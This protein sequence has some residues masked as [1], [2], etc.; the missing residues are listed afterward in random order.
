MGLVSMG[1]QNLHSLYRL[2][3]RTEAE[4]LIVDKIKSI[5]EKAVEERQTASLMLSG[6]ST[7]KNV[8]SALSDQNLPWENVTIGL[9]DD[10]WVDADKPGSNERMLNETLMQNYA[11]KA[12]LIGMKT[13]HA[14][15]NQGA[16]VVSEKYKKIQQ[17]FDLCLMG[18]GTDGHT[19][20]WFPGSSG[21]EQALNIDNSELACAIDASNSP[22]AGK[23]PHRMTLSLPAVMNSRQI[24]LFITGEEKLSVLQASFESSVDM[25]PVKA[26]LAAGARLSVFWAP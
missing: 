2:D 23:F 15:V 4:A 12:R 10:R 17:P 6:G 5:V 20:S 7:P 25:M 19:A 8:Y 3:N 16:P 13:D 14:N 24:F 11:V 26:L 9:V 21:F 1:I 18:M 22:G